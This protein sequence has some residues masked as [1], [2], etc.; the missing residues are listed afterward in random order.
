MRE[1]LLE[2]LAAG[3][4]S[5]EQAV[6]AAGASP[7][8]ALALLKDPGFVQ[9]LLSRSFQST[10]AEVPAIMKTLAARARA[11]N[12]DHVT[13]LLSLIG[14]R[15]PFR[16]QLDPDLQSMSS[17]ALENRAKAVLRDL[18]RQFG[19]QALRE[20]ADE[21]EAEVPDPGL[22]DDPDVL[23]PDGTGLHDD[24]PGPGEGGDPG[25]LPGP[26]E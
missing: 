10:I 17:V 21:I 13:A 6:K 20:L 19:P 9:D 22:P 14:D 11:G 3:E 24:W 5:F 12:R 26:G 2:Q 8:E 1:R 23:P 25:E 15:S 16:A 7:D 18:G 4:L